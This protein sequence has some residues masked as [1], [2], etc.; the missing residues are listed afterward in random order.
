M[1]EVKKLES[2]VVQNE[3]EKQSMEM[4]LVMDEMKKFY[5]PHEKFVDPAIDAYKED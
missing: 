2:V 5:Y 3:D 4:T 1:K